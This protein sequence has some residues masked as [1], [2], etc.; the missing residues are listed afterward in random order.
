MK[1]VILNFLQ[2]LVVF[3]SILSVFGVGFILILPGNCISPA[4]PFMFLF[5]PLVTM[6]SYFILINATSKKFI[7][8]LNYFL[9]TTMIKLFTFIG[10]IIIYILLNKKDAVPFVLSFFILYLCFTIFEVVQ[11]ISYSKKE[12]Q[13]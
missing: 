5:F 13:T 10:L 7:R 3:S 1:S 12:E 9:G 6:A 2:K 4:L 8:F 11:I